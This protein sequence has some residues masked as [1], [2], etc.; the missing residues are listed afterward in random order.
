ML[1][2]H[3]CLVAMASSQ[4]VSSP[5]H[6]RPYRLSRATVSFLTLLLAGSALTPLTA[7]P[8][9]ADSANS[10]WSVSGAFLAGM[11]AKNRGDMKTAADLLPLALAASPDDPGLM[12]AAL[13]AEI[14]DGRIDE[15]IKIA[16]KAVAAKSPAQQAPLVTI[17]MIQDAIKQKQ[18][19]HA[20]D[21]ARKLPDQ[22][23]GKYAGPMIRAWLIAGNQKQVAPAVKELKA[24]ES[25]PGFAPFA[26]IQRAAIEDFLGHPDDAMKTY[27]QAVDASNSISTLLLQMYGNLLVRR[28]DKAGLDK[29]LERFASSNAG[30]SDVISGPLVTLLKSGDKQKPLVNSAGDGVAGVMSGMSVLLLQQNLYSEALL[31]A[32]LGLDLKPDLD[33]GRILAG[34]IY[35]R[36][37]RYDDAVSMYSGVKPDSIYSWSARL[38]VADCLQRENKN[39]EAE[40]LLRDMTASDK[41]DVEAPELLGDLLRSSSKFEAAADAYTTAIARVPNPLPN[42]WSLF[43]FRG[44]SYERSNQWPKAE[45]D[46]KKALELSPDQPYVLNYLAYTWVERREHLDEALKMLQTAVDA[47]PEEGFIVD[48]LG[49]AHYQLGHYQDAVKYL[50]RAVALS[51]QDPT[52]NDHLGDAYWRAGRHIEAR[53]QWSRALSFKPEDDQVKVIEGKVRDG[54]APLPA[55]ATPGP[56]DNGKGSGQSGTDGGQNGTPAAVKQNAG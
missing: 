42:D 8:A 37:N 19:D 46:F 55:G 49:W 54:L 36:T 44:T 32:R 12:Q 23:I 43:Y 22:Q 30:S 45:A 15:G 47:R 52:L 18:Y 39:D 35:R 17:M 14:S 38:S 9:R 5:R 51:P 10:Q 48:S 4:P 29:L 41:S 1:A 50:E 56:D 11:N 25:E 26:L 20:L 40:K 2:T 31:F 21:F 34:D 24:L 6:P 16:K 27:Q 13:Y 3:F 53:F 7:A 28:G 33:I